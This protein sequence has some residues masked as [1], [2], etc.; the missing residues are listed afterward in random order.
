MSVVCVESR[1]KIDRK[2]CMMITD[3]DYL[4]VSEQ[5][6]TQVRFFNNRECVFLSER[7]RY[8]AYKKMNCIFCQHALVFHIHIEDTKHA[9]G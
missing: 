9:E 6:S 4:C 3:L 5:G 2:V 1:K 7:E 8:E